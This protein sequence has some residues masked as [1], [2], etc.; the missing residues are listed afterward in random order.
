MDVP[1]AVKTA[2]SSYQPPPLREIVSLESGKTTR[3]ITAFYGVKLEILPRVHGSHRPMEWACLASVQ[4]RNERKRLKI[5][6]DATTGATSHLKDK[7][8]IVGA[9][10][11]KTAKRKRDQSAS[12]EVTLESAVYK[13][14][15]SRYNCLQFTKAF[16][17]HAGC[18]FSLADHDRVRRC[19]AT[20]CPDHLDVAAINA[21]GATCIKKMIVEMYA[22]TTRAFNSELVKDVRRALIPILYLNCDLWTSRVSGEKYIGVR[23]CYMNENMVIKSFML[24]VKLFRPK[25][26]VGMDDGKITGRVVLKW[27]AQVLGQHGLRNENFAGAVS[28]SGSDVSTGI[29]KAF[30][31]EWC[32]PHMIN[33]VTIDGTGMSNS[34]ASSKNHLCRDLL[35]KMKKIIQHF[36]RSSG[37][38]ILLDDELE[39][40]SEGNWNHAKLAQAVVQRWVSTAKMMFRILEQFTAI[41]KCFVEKGKV[42]PLANYKTEIEEVYSILR[43]V[44][45]VTE[46]C[47]KTYEATM[48]GGLRQTVQLLISTL[49]PSKPL[50]VHHVEAIGADAPDPPHTDRPHEDLTETGR[51]TRE[52]FATALAKRFLPRYKSSELN[53]RT[54]LFDHAPLLNPRTRKMRYIELLLKSTAAT[55][56]SGSCGT[57][58]TFTDIKERIQEE[59]LE[60]LEQ[61]VVEHRAREPVPTSDEEVTGP[62]SRTVPAATRAADD[63]VGFDDSEG[64]EEESSSLYERS[65]EEE[66]KSILKEW[67]NLLIPSDK[68]GK[69]AADY[70][71][72]PHGKSQPLPL[73]AVAQGVL[74]CPAS[75]GAME[76]DFSIADMFMPRKRAS[77]DPAYFEMSLFLRAQYDF[78]PDDV[79]KFANEAEQTAAI[80]NRL[81]DEKL[82]EAVRVLDVDVEETSDDPDDND[83]LWSLKDPARVGDMEEGG[84]ESAED[85]SHV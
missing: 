67:L 25:P 2:I 48:E 53:R 6:S 44:K 65:P 15:P 3:S 39:E 9:A 35:E 24:G 72:T 28:D 78:I 60:L 16:I 49:E 68:R 75:T 59:V 29:A 32:I 62:R 33:R 20:M 23:V 46:Y 17:I 52:V 19:L 77:V 76:R 82:L 34:P 66:A 8:G 69:D 4:C 70:W 58:A 85:E 57:L 13:D 80:P 26:G 61:A 37:D 83:E 12:K 84:G 51:T 31:R 64:E 38:K 18:A 27:N 22:A 7:H 5:F 54:H 14:D 41:Q 74:G 73:R 81:R 36:N 42:F 56:Y 1:E 71:S 40:L 45:T 21:R 11:A 47:Q 50:R 30:R 55:S 63:D 43:A 10:S 79:P